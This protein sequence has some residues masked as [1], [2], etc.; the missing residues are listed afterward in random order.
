MGG[1]GPSAD[2]PLGIDRPSKGLARPL[3]HLPLPH[4]GS[5]CP[6]LRNGALERVGQSFKTWVQILGCEIKIALQTAQCLSFLLSELGVI[7][8]P[9]S[10]VLKI[11]HKCSG[12]PQHGGCSVMETAL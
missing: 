4:H 10:I 3:E 12:V 7:I 8:N 6:P 2:L 11:D 1:Q 9:P 5:Q